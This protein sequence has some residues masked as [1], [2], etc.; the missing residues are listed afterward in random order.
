MDTSQ[1]SRKLH[2]LAAFG[3]IDRKTSYYLYLV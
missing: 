3:R 2:L 1:F